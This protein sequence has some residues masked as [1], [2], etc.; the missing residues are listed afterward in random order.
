M[1]ERNFEIPN[2]EAIDASSPDYAANLEAAWLSIGKEMQAIQDD[3]DAFSEGTDEGLVARLKKAGLNPQ[4]QRSNIL[5]VSGS[6]IGVSSSST[7]GVPPE[8]VE[9][10]EPIRNAYRDETDLREEGYEV[11][12]ESLSEARGGFKSAVLDLTKVEPLNTI[13]PENAETLLYLVRSGNSEGA[14][15]YLGTVALDCKTNPDEEKEDRNYGF[16]LLDILRQV[17]SIPTA[18]LERKEDLKP[19]AFVDSGYMDDF[20]A[21]QKEVTGQNVYLV[22]NPT[23]I[24]TSN[25][26]LEQGFEAA[27]KDI[28]VGCEKYKTHA[29]ED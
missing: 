26:L 12:L 17:V 20:R 22:T 18:T 16:G 19:E 21:Q 6:G 3:A 24:V 29:K 2:L 27:K 28:C 10:A 14:G 7:V 8:Q 1:T 4:V 23:T 13:N 9:K 11:R 25:V 5:I 15:V